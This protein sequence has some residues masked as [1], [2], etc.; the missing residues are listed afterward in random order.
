MKLDYN[1]IIEGFRENLKLE[2]ERKEEIKK[3]KKEEY[4]NRINF[5][6][7]MLVVGFVL[8]FLLL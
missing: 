7:W 5:V 8:L 3:R 2:M 4:E 1:L 6:L